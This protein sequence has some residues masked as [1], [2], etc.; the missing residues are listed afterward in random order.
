M[1]NV[2]D[3][4]RKKR[5]HAVAGR[6]MYDYR[7]LELIDGIEPMTRDGI[8]LANADQSQP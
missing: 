5:R 4:E 1:R 6:D 8:L 3:T 2:L 7:V